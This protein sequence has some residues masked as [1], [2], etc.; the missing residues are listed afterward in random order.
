M[1]QILLIPYIKI[2]FPKFY[3]SIK[4]G[5]DRKAQTSFFI[6]LIPLYIWSGE[7]E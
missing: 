6:L 3:N 4:P 7:K 1:P 2:K 5:S